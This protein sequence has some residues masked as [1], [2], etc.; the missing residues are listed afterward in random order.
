[1]RVREALAEEAALAGGLQPDEEDEFHGGSPPDA[2]PTDRLTLAP[3]P[4]MHT[5]RATP[6]RHSP[7]RAG[8]EPRVYLD[9]LALYAA[10]QLA[11]LSRRMC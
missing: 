3:A 11:R 10:A 5:A 1:M 7:R 4:R 8:V 6:T 9:S 2:A